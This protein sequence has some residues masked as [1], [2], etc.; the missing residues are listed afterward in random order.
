M[1]ILKSRST[2]LSP[3][4]LLMT[5]FASGCALL[6]RHGSSGYSDI[7]SGGYGADSSPGRFY[8]ERGFQDKQLARQELGLKD[9]RS[10]SEEEAKALDQRLALARLEDRLQSKRDKSQYYQ[11]KGLMK[12]DAERIYFLKLPTYE[13]RSRWA[14][15]RNLNP[16]GSDFPEDVQALIENN[17]IGTGMSKRAVL[18]SW[19]DPTSEE[20]AGNPIYGNEAWKYKKTISTSSGYAEEVRVVYFEAGQVVGWEVLN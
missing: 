4:L 18:E 14:S 10:L 12:S 17:D 7:G 2:P 13:A 3:F 5:L 15:Q 9:S 19:G 1:Q 16:D 20:F 11:L 6:P 8:Q